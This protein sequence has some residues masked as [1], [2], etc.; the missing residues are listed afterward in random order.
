M[1]TIGKITSV[2]GLICFAVGVVCLILFAVGI[3]FYK[4]WVWVSF[5]IGL[6]LVSLGLISSSLGEISQRLSRLEII[7]HNHHGKNI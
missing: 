1:L 4:E 7:L 5:I 2:L 6:S 3:I